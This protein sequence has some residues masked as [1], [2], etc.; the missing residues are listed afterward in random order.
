MRVS[1]GG[2]MAAARLAHFRSVCPAENP[3][4]LLAI[5]A[6]YYETGFEVSR[7]R[8]PIRSRCKGFQARRKIRLKFDG[9]F[10]RRPTK[11][12]VLART[13]SG[14]MVRRVMWF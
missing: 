2:F 10:W 8:N 1:H 6:G 3:P 9:R 7:H 13:I 11:Q 5:R 14:L 12:R 4:S